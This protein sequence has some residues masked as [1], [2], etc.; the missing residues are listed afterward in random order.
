MIDGTRRLDVDNRADMGMS[1]REWQEH[2]RFDQCA[3][4]QEYLRDPVRKESLANLLALCLA[5]VLKSHRNREADFLDGGK[6][7]H[8]TPAML[9]EASPAPTNSDWLEH[10]FGILKLCFDRARNTTSRQAC[11]RSLV[12]ANHTISDY[13]MPMP[14]Q[15]KNALSEAAISVGR[16]LEAEQKKYEAEERTAKCEASMQAT[17]EGKERAQK[18]KEK[19]EKLRKEVVITEVAELDRQISAGGG[20]KR[21]RGGKQVEISATRSLLQSQLTVYKKIEEYSR[22]VKRL[23]KVDASTFSFSWSDPSNKTS[24][25]KPKVV[26]TPIEQLDQWLRMLIQRGVAAEV[27]RLQARESGGSGDGGGGGGGEAQELQKEQESGSDE[28]SSED[29]GEDNGGEASSM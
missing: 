16:E 2:V 28:E 20:L 17:E 14:V 11:N 24:G 15:E 8:V 9:E 12:Q 5:E 21:K 3:E 7:R 13:L 29:E 6:Y 23:A 18:T 27:A 4:V 25:G 10:V 26:K 22:V 19:K 1:E